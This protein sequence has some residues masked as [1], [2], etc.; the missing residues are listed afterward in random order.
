M[1]KFNVVQVAFKN[2]KTSTGVSDAETLIKKFLTKEDTY[3]DLLGKIAQN[4]KMMA[5][6]KG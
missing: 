3:G 4:Q 1:M 6:Y 2:I 5:I